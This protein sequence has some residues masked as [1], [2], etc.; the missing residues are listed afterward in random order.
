MLSIASYTRYSA[1]LLCAGSISVFLSPEIKKAFS[2]QG[3]L[4]IDTC[5]PMHGARR[6]GLDSFQ[7]AH[8]GLAFEARFA[9]AR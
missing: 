9:I 3:V 4:L 5:M 6:S 7:F 2:R 8:C 1:G